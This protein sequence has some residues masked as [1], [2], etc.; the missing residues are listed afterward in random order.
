MRAL[1]VGSFPPRQ[2]GIAT[3]TNDLVRAY[4]SQH[5][6]YSEVVALDDVGDRY[7]YSLRAIGRIARNDLRSYDSAAARINA[8]PSEIVNVQHEYGLFGGDDGSWALR[9]LERIRKPVVLTLHT[10]LPEPSSK[11]ERLARALGFRSAH[12]VVLS[13]TAKELL[14]ARYGFDPK[15]VTVIPHGV[16]DFHRVTRMSAKQSLG[17]ANRPV[18]ST[19]GLLS[20]GKGLE[21][22]VSAIQE[23]ARF[24]PDVHYLIIGATHPNVIRSEGERYRE[25]LLESIEALGLAGNVST[26]NRYLTLP[27]LIAYL[28]ATDVYV[29]PYLNPDQVVSGTL[30][31]A[32]AAGKAI[33]STPYLYARELLSHGRGVLAKFQDAHSL[34]AGITTFLDAPA[35]RAIAEGRAYTL[36]RS[37]LWDRVAARYG[38]LFKSLLS[39]ESAPAT[40]LADRLMRA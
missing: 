35:F 20:E 13:R 29:T 40:R 4:D 10:V 12:V 39:Y 8:H 34:A 16:H 2:C 31:Y 30:A 24:Y 15:R 3:F 25:G 17:L 11:H 5:R 9:L 23:V 18:V 37:M 28:Q 36:G 7:F 14:V 32:L 21:Y 22:A 26:I 38:E 33:V 19:F 6:D 1:F 27:E